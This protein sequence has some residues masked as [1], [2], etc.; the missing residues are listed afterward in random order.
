M[1]NNGIRSII[2]FYGIFY[3]IILKKGQLKLLIT[4]IATISY[5]RLFITYQNKIINLFFFY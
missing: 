4:K 2:S 1:N 5:E 3:D